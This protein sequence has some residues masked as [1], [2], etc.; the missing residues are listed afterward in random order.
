[1]ASETLNV[2][3]VMLALRLLFGARFEVS[4][5][6]R[7]CEPAA[8]RSK[9]VAESVDGEGNANRLVEDDKRGVVMEARR[10]L[11]PDRT[12]RES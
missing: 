8:G 1:V 12:L 5:R 4:L 9:R 6:P 7:S 2:C 3:A 10:A 11:A